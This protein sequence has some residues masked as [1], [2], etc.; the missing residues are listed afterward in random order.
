MTGNDDVGGL[1]GNN[2]GALPAVITATYATGDVT[3]NANVGGLV[4][5]NAA[6]ISASYSI[7]PVTGSS[8]AGGLVGSSSGAS[9]VIAASYWSTEA[10]G[11]TTSGGGEGKTND[12]LT[13][14]TGYTGIY[15]MWD[16]YDVDGGGSGGDSPWDFRGAD[17]L[18][19]LSVD[20]DGDGT[21]TWQ[22]FGDPRLEKDYDVDDDGLIEVETLAQLNA[23]RWDLDGDGA[24]TDLAHTT[25]DETDFYAAAFPRPLAATSTATAMGCPIGDHDGDSNTP[26]APGCLGYELVEDLDFDEDDDGDITS[27]DAAYWNGGAG[28]EPIGDDAS[29]FGAA[30]EGNGHTIA[31]LFINRPDAAASVALFG[32]VGASGVVRNLGLTD[33]NITGNAGTGGLVGDNDGSV[34]ASY[35]TGFVTGSMDE[36][37]GLVGENDGLVVASYSAASVTGG[38][39]AQ[40]GGLVG[41]NEDRVQASYATGAAA[42]S[43]ADAVGG[44]VGENA[45]GTINAS[46]ATSRVSG[47][48]SEPWAAWSATQRA[49][50]H[51]KRQLLGHRGL[52]AVRQRRRRPQDHRAVALAHELHR[53]LRRLERPG[54]RRYRR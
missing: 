28:W 10:S 30:F 48:G 35:V 31:N 29:S 45:G 25:E 36:I 40:V 6:G 46:Y 47:S 21:A 12:E 39:G 22:E 53:H 9:A 34:I 51:G 44:L 32:G 8:N 16:D 14:P 50:C 37:G 11:L 41:K 19:A 49:Q 7:G 13:T 33:V 23:I 43:S 20:F 18:P 24:A 42:G 4:G 15:E 38:S 5:D 1:V 26:D 17:R 2:A 54:R 27:A 52:G 3:G